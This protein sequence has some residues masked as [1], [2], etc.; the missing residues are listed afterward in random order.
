MIPERVRPIV[1]ECRPLAERFADLHDRG[2]ERIY[3]WFCDFAPPRTLEAFGEH[4]IAAVGA[5]A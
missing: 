2:F 1:D 5:P 4:V 3:A